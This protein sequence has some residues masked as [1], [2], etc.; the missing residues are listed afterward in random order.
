MLP[1]INEL[2]VPSTGV[3]DH[4]RLCVWY[5]CL[6]NSN[7]T[8]TCQCST[9]EETTI[10]MMAQTSFLDKHPSLKWLPQ[11]TESLKEM[12]PHF[13]HCLMFKL[14]R[15]LQNQQMSY[16]MLTGVCSQESWMLIY[17]QADFHSNK[18]NWTKS[19]TQFMGGFERSPWH[20]P[21]AQPITSKKAVWPTINESDPLNFLIWILVHRKRNYPNLE[22]RS[23]GP[24]LGEILPCRNAPFISNP[25][26]RGNSPN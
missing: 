2:F 9:K 22:P 11:Q 6:K 21:L 3:H 12:Q 26:I 16:G 8:G 23:V 18:S 14:N 1:I 4:E 17:G 15:S 10:K 5:F 25:L 13:C 19:T 24:R 7:C 20:L